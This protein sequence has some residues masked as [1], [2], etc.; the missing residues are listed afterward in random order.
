VSDSS[1]AKDGI[2]LKDRSAAAGIPEY[3]IVDARPAVPVPTLLRQ[4]GRGYPEM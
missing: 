4:V 2:R 1:V 3:W